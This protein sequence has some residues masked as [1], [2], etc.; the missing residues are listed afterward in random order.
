MHT[1]RAGRSQSLGTRL[2]RNLPL[3]LLILP[4]FVG[5]G[6]FFYYPAIS[7]FYHSFTYWDAYGTQWAGLA[8]YQRLIEDTRLLNSFG[9]LAKVVVFYVGVVLTMPLLAATLMFHLRNLRAQYWFRVLFVFPMVV[10]AVVTILVWRWMYSPTGGI[11]QILT[12]GGLQTLTHNWLGEADTVLWAILFVGF[13]WVA[14][15]NTLIYLAGLQAI[16]Q[17]VLDAAIVDGA[18]AFGRFF[19]VELPLIS[20]QI[21][22]LVVLTLVWWL[23]SFEAFLIM[24]DGGPGWA[25]LVPGLRMYHSVI[26]D[27]ELGYGSAIGFVLFLLIFLVTLM[28][29]RL[30]RGGP[31]S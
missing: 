8:N 27:F 5:L 31:E 18:N 7:G 1:I 3:Y 21:K 16:S 23:K 6:L 15:L 25:S 20:G 26:R 17:E 29:M 28:Q 4:T 13:P 22:L 11:N 30:Q 19:R 2:K 24:T 9:N 14:G 10:P 12:V